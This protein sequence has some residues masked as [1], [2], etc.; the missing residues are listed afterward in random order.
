MGHNEG[1]KAALSRFTVELPPGLLE[2]TIG[3]HGSASRGAERGTI[4]P[5]AKKACLPCQVHAGAAE[6]GGMGLLP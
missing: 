2:K 5:I 6:L 1:G 4:E 3:R